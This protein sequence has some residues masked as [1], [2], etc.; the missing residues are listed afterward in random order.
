MVDSHILKPASEIASEHG[1][2]VFYKQVLYRM[3]DRGQIKAY[4]HSQTDEL[5]FDA[6]Q[7]IDAYCN[8]IR[9][10][11]K[12]RYNLSFKVTYTWGVA[13]IVLE[14]GERVDLEWDTN[15][16]TE[17]DFY[18]QKLEPSLVKNELWHPNKK[19]CPKCGSDTRYQYN[20]I[21]NGK[22]IGVWQC[23]KPGCFTQIF[24]SINDIKLFGVNRR[25]C[26][27][28]YKKAKGVSYIVDLKNGARSVGIVWLNCVSCK[29]RFLGYTAD[30]PLIFVK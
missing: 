26:K 3:A 22:V 17:T 24:R 18:G 10:R 28:C 16:L 6:K 14:S 7:V 8:I 27:D 12:E 5:L 29:K 11:I 2:K 30:E 13:E 20:R 19:V 15:S 23:I 25:V 4:R 21:T 1:S 9:E